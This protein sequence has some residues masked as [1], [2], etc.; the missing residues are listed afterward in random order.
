ML[1]L[2]TGYSLGIVR[3]HEAPGS[4][5]VAGFWLGMS[6]VL[7]LHLFAAHAS[8]YLAMMVQ[9]LII[10]V[11]VP[12]A[13]YIH[14]W[15]PVRPVPARQAQAAQRALVGILV[16]V[17]RWF[18]REHQYLAALVEPIDQHPQPNTSAGLTNWI[19]RKR[20]GAVPCLS[21]HHHQACA[22][23]DPPDRDGVLFRCGLLASH[24]D[25]P[26]LMG[27]PILIADFWIDLTTATV[28]LAY[29][30]GGVVLDLYRLDR[31]VMRV[32]YMSRRHSFWSVY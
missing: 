17:E 2:L 13:I 5:L 19:H 20:R 31:I 32:A 15:Y 16:L 24:T 14:V 8:S 25:I 23:P 1:C 10:V 22:P 4:L 27:K 29:L 7:G 3:R 30:V 9:W 11:L 6:I 21:A 26:M 28:P 18:R 12:L